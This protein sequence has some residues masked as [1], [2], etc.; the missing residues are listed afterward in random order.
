VLPWAKEEVS[1][2]ATY[3]SA[4]EKICS[5]D[6]FG[7]N[8]GLERIRAILRELGNP[9][10]SFRCV[11]V[12]G[13]NG[14]GS[15]VEMIGAVLQAEGRKVGTYFSPQVREFPERIRIGGKNAKR[16]EI[17]HAYETVAIAAR[18]VAPKATFFEVVTAMA[19]LIF[20]S[21]GVDFAVLE[22]G[23]GGRLDAT[24]A[25]EPEVSAIT[26]LSLEH[27]DVLGGTIEKI[28][29]E[30][31]GIARREKRLVCGAVGS[32][33]GLAIAKECAYAGARAVFVEDEIGVS[34]L[35]ESGGK[36]S[37]HAV[38]SGKKYSI[39][40]SA[41][42]RFQLSN[43]CVALAVCALLGAGKKAIE[44]G[45]H[46]AKPA[47]RLQR[48]SSSPTVIADCCHNPEAALAL[49]KEVATMH[50]VGRKVLLFSAMRDKD[51]A[52]VLATLAPLFSHVVVTKVNLARGE[53]LERLSMAAKASGASPLAVQPAKMALA[54]AKDEAG[55][56]GLV[57]VAGSIYLLSELFGKDGAKV[58][59]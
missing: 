11:L 9:Q 21:R 47:F 38:Y 19:L 17:I 51:Y 28:A 39:S 42:G 55:E 18:R 41:P 6:K 8:L 22:V 43:A 59:Q 58:A 32:R 10:K 26:S 54:T 35:A 1:I 25:V 40:L 53:E 20:R 13:S 50:V 29:H 24:N 2:V 49:A 46:K 52:S 33:A 34:D 36:H 44:A 12:G 4:L 15:T 14:K 5:L 45:L 48:V 57:V 37:F 16:S 27:A 30:K 56:N 7:S 3:A 31:C 23:L